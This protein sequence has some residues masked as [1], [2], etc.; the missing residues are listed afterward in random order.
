MYLEATSLS[1]QQQTEGVIDLG[2]SEQ[3]GPTLR[4]VAVPLRKPSSRC[5]SEYTHPHIPIL[6]PNR[7]AVR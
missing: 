4:A 3:H 2:V 1:Q 5:G 6:H 7:P